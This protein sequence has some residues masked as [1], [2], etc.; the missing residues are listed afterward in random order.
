LA[1]L[2]VNLL[3]VAVYDVVAYFALPP[4]QSVSYWLQTWFSSWPMLAVFAGIMIGHLC[5]PLHRG[6]WHPRA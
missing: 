3:V 6:D 1:A 4:D 2:L 5:W